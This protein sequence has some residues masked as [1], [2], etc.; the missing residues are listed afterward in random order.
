MDKSLVTESHY[1]TLSSDINAIGES[2]IDALVDY[3]SAKYSVML[4]NKYPFVKT[5]YELILAYINY[6][7]LLSKSRHKN[8]KLYNIF[9]KGFKAKI[10]SKNVKLKIR[11][12]LVPDNQALTHG[13][14]ESKAYTFYTSGSERKWPIINLDIPHLKEYWKGSTRA[15][16]YKINDMRYTL[17]HELTHAMQEHVLEKDMDEVQIKKLKSDMGL[18]YILYYLNPTE[19]EAKLYEAFSKFKTLNAQWSPKQKRNY[20]YR[21]HGV[22]EFKDLEGYTFFIKNVANPTGRKPDFNTGRPEYSYTNILAQLIYYDFGAKG[23]EKHNFKRLNAIETDLLIEDRY[24]QLYILKYILLK[25]LPTTKFYN[26]V[27]N[28]TDYNL[29]ASKYRKENIDGI[30]KY[31]TAAVNTIIDNYKNPEFD[32]GEALDIVR[33]NQKDAFKDINSA[34]EFNQKIQNCF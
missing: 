34:K 7:S 28:D 10:G 13:D 25:V 27:K 30:W 11:L 16:I 18:N 9:S 5:K 4:L 24:D 22:E 26:Y 29:F 2:F 33:S 3:I 8:K 31:I 23:F 21:R 15:F 17:T 32:Y 6:K 19:I 14:Y 1:R 12:N 20:M